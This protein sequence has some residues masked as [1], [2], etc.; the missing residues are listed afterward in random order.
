MT[1]EV[2][3]LDLDLDPRLLANVNGVNGVVVAQFYH[4]V[5]GTPMFQVNFGG[6][7]GARSVRVGDTTSEADVVMF[8]DTQRT[9]FAGP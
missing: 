4:D 2:Q 7:I 3:T 6:V 8:N 1:V 9:L 5:T